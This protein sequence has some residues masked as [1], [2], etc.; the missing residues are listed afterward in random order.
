MRTFEFMVFKTVIETIFT[1]MGQ[2]IN[3]IGFNFRTRERAK[4]THARTHT[5]NETESGGGAG[6]KDREVHALNG[7]NILPLNFGNVLVFL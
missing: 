7:A 2:F 1:Y 4:H 6:G 3:Q 5:H